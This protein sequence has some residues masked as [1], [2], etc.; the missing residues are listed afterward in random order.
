MQVILSTQSV[1]LLNEF[2]L[3][4]IIVVERE[5]GVSTFKRH[6]SKDFELW[7]EDYT[8]GELWEKNVL[9]GIP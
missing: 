3:E 9:G 6:N 5:D 8:I 4:D 7:L 1:L 2:E